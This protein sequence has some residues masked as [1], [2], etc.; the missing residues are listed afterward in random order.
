[1][2]VKFFTLIEL[3]IVVAIIAVLCA[4]LLPALNGARSKANIIS[5]LNNAKE[6]GRQM[7][8]YANDSHAWIPVGVNTGDPHSNWHETLLAFG[9]HGKKKSNC[10]KN[11]ICRCPGDPDFGIAYW[12]IDGAKLTEKGGKKT[13]LAPGSGFN[14]DGINIASFPSPSTTVMFTEGAWMNGEGK[15]V[16]RYFPSGVWSTYYV[17]LRHQRKATFYWMDGHAT[18]GVTDAF[19]RAATPWNGLWAENGFIDPAGILYPFSAFRK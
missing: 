8:M 9:Y 10:Q 16:Y 17:Y 5:C 13:S 14:S 3:L 11:A 4:L 2:K 18:N 6:C 19:S 1:M 7:L 12:T 15:P